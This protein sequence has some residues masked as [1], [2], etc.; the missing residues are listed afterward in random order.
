MDA[1]RLRSRGD[2]ELSARLLALPEVK[3]YQV[4]R[5]RDPVE[6]T[7]R[8]L[9]AQAVRLTP[10]MAPALHTAVDHCRTVIGVDIPVELYVWPS[11]G[12]NAFSFAAERGRGF[13]GVTS[14][15]LEGFEDRELR[16]VIGHELGHLA[17][18]HHDVPVALLT[19]RNTGLSADQVLTVFQWQRWAE[20]SADRAGLACAGEVAPAATAF[21]KLASGLSHQVVK[22]D[23]DEFLKQLGDLASESEASRSKDDGPTADW[24]S[25]HP[26]SPVRVRAVQ[27]AATS[28]LIDPK[29]TAVAVLEDSVTDLMSLTD[30][31]YL[32]EPGEIGEAMRRLLLA[33]GAVVASAGGPLE[34]EEHAALETLLGIGA[35]PS[36]INVAA[37]RDDLERRIARVNEVVP[38]PRRA[39]VIRDLAVIAR[40]DGRVDPAEVAEI[41]RIAAAV[42][43]DPVIVDS[44]IALTDKGL[45]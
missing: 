37:L 27:L 3:L 28:E 19:D 18:S 43:V 36:H 5:E 6:Q 21:F 23:I 31:S 4:R 39:Q 41:R 16:F 22:F 32:H 7:R 1:H 20:I 15:I 34:D 13:V 14:S 25:S 42:D 12:Y 17:F 38:A 44:T 35:V 9:L 2:I 11:P 29:G 24:F 10:A 45:D 30:P 40:A 8:Q 26:L 33:G